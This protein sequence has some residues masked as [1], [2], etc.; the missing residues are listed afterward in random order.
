MTIE[1]ICFTSTRTCYGFGFGLSLWIA[2]SLLRVSE[3]HTA[4]IYHHPPKSPRWGN[5]RSYRQ[6]IMVILLKHELRVVASN[7][8]VDDSYVQ[9]RHRCKQLSSRSISMQQDTLIAR[10]LCGLGFIL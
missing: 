5:R 10:M 6:L 2:L 7:H 8:L 1:T 4:Y 3:S 9:A